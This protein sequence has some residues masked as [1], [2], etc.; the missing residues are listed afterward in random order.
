MSYYNGRSKSLPNIYK[1]KYSAILN[2]KYDTKK[3]ETCENNIKQGEVCPCKDDI[4]PKP[5]PQTDKFNKYLRKIKKTF[6][7]PKIIYI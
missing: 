3:C 5:K 7:E 4:Y 1:Y 6:S 2:E